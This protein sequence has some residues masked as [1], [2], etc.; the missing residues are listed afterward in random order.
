MNTAQEIIEDLMQ[1]GYVPGKPALGISGQFLNQTLA[2]ANNLPIG[3]YVTSVYTISDA[4]L[5]GLREGDVITA[6]DDVKLTDL[7]AYNNIIDSHS[8]GDEVC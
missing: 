4:Y 1:Y 6:I 7:L 8:A 2:S 3:L 5:K